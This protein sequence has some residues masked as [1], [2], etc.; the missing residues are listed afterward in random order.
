MMVWSSLFLAFAAFCAIA[1]S[2]DR[3]SDE[4][5]TQPLGSRQRLLWRAAGY[6]LLAVSL[7]PCLLQWGPSVALASWVGLLAFSAGALGLMLTYC[8][9]Q[10]RRAAPAAAAL[11]A[12]LWLA[13][14]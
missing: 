9:P 8:T 3:H 11:G 13:L 14:R 4:L 6:V 1:S 2:M 12:L 10:L 5:H 7:L